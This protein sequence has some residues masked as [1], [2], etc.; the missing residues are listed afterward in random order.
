MGNIQIELFACRRTAPHLVRPKHPI[1]DRTDQLF[2]ASGDGG[3]D[4]TVASIDK[5]KQ[6]D[7]SDQV[8]KINKGGH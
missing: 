4:G 8:K 2:V 3:G 6:C 5:V 7:Q 1:Y